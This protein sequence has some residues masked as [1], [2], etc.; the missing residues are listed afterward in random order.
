MYRVSWNRSIESV[1]IREQQLISPRGLHLTDRSPGRVQVTFNLLGTPARKNA[2]SLLLHSPG[3]FKP[4]GCPYC[5][6]GRPYVSRRPRVY[7]FAAAFDNSSSSPLSCL[8]KRPGIKF[9]SPLSPGRVD[10]KTR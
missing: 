1:S 4:P 2:R 5:V 3:F 8:S 10:G 6:I 9:F 7:T